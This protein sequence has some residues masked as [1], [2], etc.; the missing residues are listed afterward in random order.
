MIYSIRVKLFAVF[1]VLLVLFQ[2]IFLITNAYF[3]D[4]IFIWG[5]KRII[6]Q[7]YYDFKD[8]YGK[9][10]DEVE[11]LHNA[12]NDYGGN[13]A[14]IDR[15]NKIGNSTY[16]RFASDR[17]GRML[18]SIRQPIENFTNQEDEDT[19]LIVSSSQD[20]RFNNIIFIGKLPDN[21]LFIA[22]K[23]YGVVYESSRIAENFIIVSG[24]GTLIIG[25][26]IVFFLSGR[27]AKPILKINDIAKEIA[28]LNFDNKVKITSKDELGTLGKSINLISHTLSQALKELRDANAKL[29][30]DIEKERKLERMRRKF[31]SNVSHELKTPLS[32]IQGYADGLKHNIAQNREESEYYCDVIIDESEKMNHLIKDLLDLSS[33]E[34]G[35]FKIVKSHFDLVELIKESTSKYR[36]T[37]ESKDVELEIVTPEE[38]MIHADRLRIEQVLRNFMSNA[39]KYVDHQGKIIVTMECSNTH[40]HIQFYNTGELINDADMNHIWSSFYRVESQKTGA[41]M[42]TGLGLAI[43]KAIIEMHKGSC[44]VLNAEAGVSFWIELPKV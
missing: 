43:V 39:E 13:I 25:S 7:I 20:A 5:N 16:S 11:Y 41:N 3:L 14:V 9:T 30:E 15:N 1:V 10:F 38:C 42:G 26:I 2:F 34:S 37:L 27:L 22:E 36:T 18:L 35:V 29:E 12:N 40:V 21:K 8:N 28:E 4:D 33:Y 19:I 6:T 44:G 31:V 24:I 17:M 32:M 23:P